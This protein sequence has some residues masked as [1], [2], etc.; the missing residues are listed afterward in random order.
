MEQA[1]IPW[2]IKSV[3]CEDI[4]N[5]D[6]VAQQ[7]NT[8]ALGINSQAPLTPTAAPQLALVMDP[9]PLAVS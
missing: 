3:A 2:L 4:R 9:R 7:A 5:R 1:I 6:L 8:E